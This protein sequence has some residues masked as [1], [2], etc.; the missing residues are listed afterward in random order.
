MQVFQ[1]K[2]EKTLLKVLAVVQEEEISGRSDKKSSLQAESPI[3]EDAR[4]RLGQ[5]VLCSAGPTVYERYT[6]TVVGMHLCLQ[7]KP[8]FHA[9]L[10]TRP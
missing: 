9:G 7:V 4:L 5:V 6:F 3:R 1:A 10:S 2:K 8:K